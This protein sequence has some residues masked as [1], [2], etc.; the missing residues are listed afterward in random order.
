MK[1]NNSENCFHR[2]PIVGK[3]FTE[4]SN[5][6]KNFTCFF[7]SLEL[8]PAR[9]PIVGKNIRPFSNR[10]NFFRVALVLMMLVTPVTSVFG[11]TT[12]LS[13]TLRG[14]SLPT[15]WTQSSVIFAT[16]AGGYARFS[17]VGAL[18]STPTFDASA[19]TSVDVNFAV[20]KFGSGGN[21]PVT[22]EYSLNGGSTWATAGDSTTPT[23]GTTYQNNTISINAVSS[24]MV[25]RF[26]RAN[27]PSQ[28]RLR[29]VVI[30]G[31]GSGG[32][33]SDSD[34]DIIRDASFT[35]PANIA[36]GSYQESNLTGSSLE[37]ARFLIRDG[38]ASADADGDDTTL[39]DLTL[40]IAN[41]A[42]VRRVALYD[43]TTEIA[44]MDAGA[45]VTFTGLSGL[46]AADDGTKSFSVRA[47]F[48]SSVTD[49]Q[50][51]SFTITAATA[52]S[53]GS[54]FAAADA[55]GAAS[56]TG[57]DANRIE[58]T[59][60]KLAF[61][62][63]PASV[64]IGANFTAAVQ[65]LDAN[66]NLDLDST[67]SVT[68]TQASG[69]GTLTGGTA[70][71]LVAGE[72]SF[73]TLQMDTEGTFRIQAAAGG[74]TSATSGDIT[75]A[76]TTIANAVDYF[77]AGGWSQAGSADWF[78]QTTTTHDGIDAA[79]SGAIGDSQSS[80]IYMDVTGPG[81]VTFWWN[82]SSEE[83]D[84]LVFYEDLDEID[85]ISGSPGWA[86]VS[87][88]ITTE[89]PV[90]L[91]WAYEK[92]VSDSVGADAGYLDQVTFTPCPTAPTVQAESD[93]GSAEF[94]ANWL[95]ASGADGYY[96]DVATADTFNAGSASTQLGES[97]DSGLSTSYQTGDITLTSGVWNVVRV[98]QETS[99]DARSG[100]AAR[101]DDDTVGAN[102]RTPALN[103]VGTVSF[104]YRELNSGGGTFKVQKSYNGTDWT[105]IE[106]VAF[107]GTTYAQYSA[108]V[109]DSA[110]TIYIRIL[111]DDNLGHLIIDDFEVTAMGG[112]SG[113]EFVSGFEGLDVGNV[114]SYEVTGLDPETTYY[115]RVRAYSAA[116]GETANSATEE[117]TTA[118]AASA[119]T[120]TTP[121][122]AAITHNSAT[123]GANVISDGNAALTEKGV[124]WAT[125]PAPETTDN[126]VA[127]GNTATGVFTVNATGLPGGTLI[128]YRGYAINSQGTSYSAEGSFYTEPA[129]QPT[130]SIDSVTASS[131][132]LSWT[133]GSG[134]GVIV[135]I[136]QGSA[137]AATP[138]D[139][140]EHSASSVFA[141]GANLGSSQYVIYRGSGS[142]VQVTGLSAGQTYHV[143]A[144]A[145]AGSSS[146]I[147][148]QQDTPGTDS[149]TT[150]AVS[151]PT[152]TTPT[153]SSITE[154]GATLGA[155]ISSDGNSTITARGTVWGES[156]NPT[157]NGLAEGGTAV[158]A[159]THARTGMPAAT[160]IYF[161]GYAVNGQGTGY[162]PDGTFWTEPSVQPTASFSLQTADSFRLSWTGGNGAG[163]LV[164]VREASAVSGA[165]V[166]GTTYTAD[167]NFGGS[168]S[169][170]GGGKVVYVGSGS[171]VDITGLNPNTAYHVALYEYAGSGPDINYQQDSPGTGST[172]TTVAAEPTVQA[173][174]IYFAT[175]NQ[176]SVVL[177]WTNGN[178]TARMVVM[179]EGAATTW[180]PT[181]GVT[182]TANA[183]FGSAVDRGDGNKVVYLGSG[184]NQTVSGLSAATQYAVTVFEYNGS[185]GAENYLLTDAPSATAFTLST[186]P[187]TAASGLVVADTN[188]YSMELQ[189]VRGDGNEVLV[190]A[191]PGSGNPTTPTD[192]QGYTANAAFGVGDDTGGGSYVVYK[193]TGTNVTITA[194][195]A[196]TQYSFR[197]YEFNRSV[198]ST[199]RY[200]VS[201]TVTETTR[202]DYQ[203]AVTFDGNGITNGSST[204]G[205]ANGTDFGE[206]V[207]SGSFSATHTFTIANSG[208]E[209]MTVS[210]VA[211][212]GTH[213]ADFSVSVEPTSP[214]AGEGSTTF[215]IVFDPSDTGTRNATV[216]F[217][218]D[219]ADES[220]FTFAI[221]GEGTADTDGPVISQF[222]F[223]DGLAAAGGGGLPDLI[224]SE[225]VEGSSNNKYIE[226]YNGT[227]SSVDLSDYALLIF[228]NGNTSPGT[229][230]ALAGTLAHGDVY[231][232]KHTSESLGVTA[233]QIATIG[234]NGNDAVALT[235]TTGSGYVDIFG[236]I[237]EDPGT[238]WTDGT[239][240]TVNKTLRRKA[241]V[242]GGITTNPTSGFPTLDSEW[243]MF[244]EDTVSG[245]GSHTSDGG[246]SPAVTW[247]TTDAVLFAG[248][249]GMT[250]IVQDAETGLDATGDG[251]P[252][253]LLFNANG[254]LV[255]SNYF[256]VS[257]SDG[258]TS[259]QTVTATAPAADSALLDLGTYDARFYI[260]DAGGSL[261]VAAVEV[262][263]TDDDTD[264][265]VLG[266][267]G[268]V[269]GNTLDLTLNTLTVTGRVADVS[270]VDYTRSYVLVRDSG[271]AVVI[272]NLLSGPA[273]AD[274]AVSATF[275]PDGMTCG[276]EYTVTVV[277][278]DADLDRG[279]IDSMGV[280]GA[281]FTVTTIGEGDPGNAPVATNLTINGTAVSPALVL[282]DADMASGGWTL[283]MGIS[284]ENGIYI[285]G[286]SPSIKITNSLGVAIDSTALVEAA[287]SGDTTYFTNSPM[288]VVAGADIE[289]G[290]HAVLWS[291]TNIGACVSAVN[292]RNLIAGG[293]NLFTVVDDDPDAPELTGFTANGGFLIT[294]TDALAGFSFTGLVQDAVSGIDI[295][296]HPPTYSVWS[297]DQE[298][299]LI[300]DA[301]FTTAPAHG[302]TAL[303]ALGAT[304][305][306]L[307]VNC[308]DTIEI[309]VTA[310]DTDNDRPGDAAEATAVYSVDIEGVSGVPP[311]ASDLAIN[312]T[313]ASAFSILDSSL[314]AGGWTVAITFTDA[315][316]VT[317]GPDAPTFR[318][319]NAAGESIYA[320]ADM[321]FDT[322]EDLG[323]GD[324][325]ATR[326]VPAPAFD[327]A[328]DVGAYEIRWSARSDGLCYGEATASGT[329][330]GGNTFTVIDDD[331]TP[332]NIIDN[333]SVA[334]GIVGLTGCDGFT[335]NLVAGDIAII[336][337]NTLTTASTNTDSFAFVAVRPIPAGTQIKFTDKGWTADNA[338]YQYE[339]V[340]T[341]TATECVDPG[342]VIIWRNSSVGAAS[343]ND[344]NS[345][346]NVNIGTMVHDAPFSSSTAFLP[347]TVGEQILAFQGTVEDPRFIYALHTGSW[348]W[349]R[350]ASDGIAAKNSAASRLPPGLVQ[351]VS[352]VNVENLNNV[353]I[354]PD[355]VS[356][357][358][359][360][361][362]VLAYIGNPDNWVANDVTVFPLNTWEF[363]FPGLGSAGGII[364]D[365]TILSGG[366][367]ITGTVVDVHSGL[368]TDG[369]VFDVFNP[370]SGLVLDGTFTNVYSTD[371][372]VEAHL[373]V[374][375]GAG[376]YA[377]NDTGTFSVVVT[378]WD[379]DG[380]RAND[381]LS[382]SLTVPFTVVDDDDTPPYFTSLTWN[383]KPDLDVAE[384]SSVVITT[385][386]GDVDSGIAFDSNPPH[387]IILDETGQAIYTNFFTEPGG[388]S[389]GAAADAE[390]ALI[391]TPPMNLSAILDCGVYT[392]RVVV[393][394][395]DDDR[396]YD[397]AV[398]N[399]EILVNLVDGSNDPTEL[400]EMEVNQLPVEMAVLTDAEIQSGGWELAVAINNASA[401]IG[402]SDGL[403]PRYTL[404]S[405]AG[406]E[407]Q[408]DLWS[409]HVVTG[410][411]FF[412]TNQIA[413]VTNDNAELIDIGQYAIEWF[414]QSESPCDGGATGTNFVQ[415]V[416]DDTEPPLMHP[417][418]INISSQHTLIHMGFEAFHGWTNAPQMAYDDYINHAG[419]DVWGGVNYRVRT[420]DAVSGSRVA[421]LADG[422]S[423][424]TLPQ[425]ANAGTLFAWTRLGEEG[426]TATVV[427][428]QSANGVDWTSSDAFAISGTNYQKLAWTIGQ[429]AETTL[430]IRRTDSSV[431]TVWLDEIS[432]TKHVA[433][434]NVSTID[435]SFDNAEDDK[436]V[437]EYR[438]ITDGVP[439]LVGEARMNQGVLLPTNAVS[440]MAI[441][442]G[443]TTG[444]VFA[445]DNDNNRPDD[446]SRS[447][448]VPYVL[449]VDRTPPPA[450]GNL[451]TLEDPLLDDI[452]EVRL[453]WTAPAT[454][455]VAAGPRADATPL[456]PWHS[457][458]FYFTDVENAEP[459]T[460]DPY[461][462]VSAGYEDLGDFSATE[463]VLS[464][465]MFGT[466]Y[467]IAVA[468]LDE[469]GNLGPL[470]APVTHYFTGFSVTQGVAV[471]HDYSRIYWEAVEGREYDLIHL[472]DHEYREEFGRDWQLS[473][474]E[475]ANSITHQ[476]DLNGYSM[477]FYR[478]SPA[479][480]WE[481]LLET[482]SGQTTSGRRRIASIEVY[483]AKPIQLHPGQN[484][485]ALP[486][487]PDTLTVRRAFG[488]DLPAGGSPALSTRITWYER[489]AG[490]EVQ[491][492][493]WLDNGI[494]YNALPGGQTEVADEW[495]V[496]L[497]DGVVIELPPN[498]PSST[499]LFVGKVPMAEDGLHTQSIAPGQAYNLTST[500]LP[501]NVSPET[502]E[503][504]GMLGAT[505]GNMSSFQ[506]DM[507]WKFDRLNQSVPDVLYYNNGAYG[508][509]P[510]WYRLA[511]WGALVPAGY[512][513]PDDGIII[514]TGG[515][516]QEWDWT[517]P[518]PYQAPT[519]YLD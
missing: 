40:S 327:L 286:G 507:M 395:A 496:D 185:A 156:A 291:A 195:A 357:A 97:F 510:G 472:D 66:D 262:V 76:N 303:S 422:N 213:A 308:G 380:D 276:E 248:G 148:Y 57:G 230:I 149:D 467:R 164:I 172:S 150:L 281:V 32:G 65:A 126:K 429:T 181:D 333:F 146:A 358:G 311:T 111:N 157:G 260:N 370:G 297:T 331:V 418:Y 233:D 69:A 307:A 110:T 328:T 414:A 489:A 95:A 460:S 495:P 392:C 242:A 125:T 440:G 514:Y 234:F 359:N 434:T 215:T 186:L 381:A 450:I 355:L 372:N 340:L 316:L 78:Y 129:T 388:F 142:S 386:V 498:A 61:D 204:P 416:D 383:G 432:L 23:T 352:A 71:A 81:V 139:G 179:R 400:G 335:T 423:L 305:S 265:P 448:G 98:F 409:E 319:L 109:N 120:V 34:S 487:I 481:P 108:T 127:H 442:E 91:T 443:V 427:F 119:P 93:V 188:A 229:T 269:G 6:W 512:F 292:D 410:S 131:M 326:T 518:V 246:L 70:Q 46:V 361:D 212:S 406:A 517:M 274:V 72:R 165:P 451:A 332:P 365:Y 105:D 382:A 282:T 368:A 241:S 210:T 329:V 123:L 477:R 300:E 96:L 356:I 309:H 272:S 321:T 228:F 459:T 345:Y 379:R 163:T 90:T 104:W 31:I 145:Y 469:A 33:G 468:G 503:L 121:T 301:T 437:F 101:I 295:D 112:G 203:I 273:G 293:T 399:Y 180:T 439:D 417:L 412:A 220:P 348:G 463:V 94:T 211:I 461:V 118:A 4:F 294:A 135:V 239:K 113:N 44:E 366:W 342:E 115:Y 107:S 499:L 346:T 360:R 317:A 478:A 19:H 87:H 421:E 200:R 39:T 1:N 250:S 324:Y 263:V 177:N 444:F 16:A 138:T 476:V 102:L 338:L 24:T 494:W 50:Q 364:T 8:F 217:T 207:A 2:F 83:Y 493:I 473:G 454:E 67:A 325:R 60:T 202:I 238:A 28:K 304:I 196:D 279:L 257:F 189:W 244:D 408:G 247:T 255:F 508:Q 216:S 5:R 103:T 136:R 75:A 147:N 369:I 424:I 183:N 313:A 224:I 13:D 137:V 491:R 480:R 302:A 243:D 453:Q 490:D 209:D 501:V 374:T 130:I 449:R 484:W 176:A 79:Q 162:S 288:P 504:T 420:A 114:T 82:V 194:L 398:L 134:D 223:G 190:V 378:A 314:M 106:S 219:D 37:V 26:N 199:E 506:F 492:Q 353:V 277:A 465:F 431:G 403:H 251:R 376:S 159:F 45:T 393:V 168:G 318:V 367:S 290:I 232:I 275:A 167:A 457:Y 394:D 231:V 59:A 206:V 48:Q 390:T 485:V 298:A 11:Q 474:R 184:T 377:Q 198:P 371:A 447:A 77:P 56:A 441:G 343:I 344:P 264:P 266:D 52:D 362:D 237:G 36:Y 312:G 256:A 214:V 415:V 283:G 27:S 402:T 154:V 462:D 268:L 428:E 323:G 337:M 173:T 455:A 306:G 452:S 425:R 404:F 350:P 253:Y 80:E 405:A 249:Y 284:H 341:W 435:I 475:A 218:H 391:W 15:G 161:R 464:N 349:P 513:K 240:T 354:D 497:T 315:N 74:L 385:R 89:G 38:G 363:D 62:S 205:A 330:V 63:V 287:T 12:L 516:S 208:V 483:A 267:F 29:D 225:Y 505:T 458:R 413:G 133:G 375:V 175:R 502:M 73:T 49:N 128:Y 54:T 182:Y 88:T 226:I 351:G 235:N 166:D 285:G 143:A 433:W 197:V 419:A 259:E 64:G 151:V 347:N 258:D 100:F 43:G 141:S 18:L 280:T 456:S 84:Y 438:A 515:S 14:G 140:T 339:G 86:Q 271:N 407:L 289:L 53:G 296:T 191:V 471:A 193:G 336:G 152:L 299:W 466:E 153:V 22:V 20:A 445:V 488:N 334:G 227:G 170:L 92:D 30:D 401:V 270:G 85:F 236:R 436:G 132:N 486:G 122:D 252:R 245:L 201:S 17:A 500:R 187:S 482:D 25:I 511:S 373:S 42:N 41:H 117:V 322:I 519:Q 3:F 169:A 278:F 261:S 446:R 51:V 222:A 387:F 35:E 58:V 144:F 396:P 10:W 192:G 7:Q 99:T 479:G 310:R 470:S 178:G 221:T 430:R 171:Q 9:F 411:G 124:V 397:G 174:G 254:D 21:G 47:S 158:S 509:T 155:T 116:C 320:T 160:L 426:E 384:L 68:I 55:G 389:D